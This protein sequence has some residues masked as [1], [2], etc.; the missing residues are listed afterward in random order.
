MGVAHDRKL[1]EAPHQTSRNANNL[2]H[3][4]PEAV[5]FLTRPNRFGLTIAAA[6]ANRQY[7]DQLSTV[8]FR[9][10]CNPAKLPAALATLHES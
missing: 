4:S 10:G 1:L 7:V 5:R 9:K 3:T 2:G 6:A 8:V